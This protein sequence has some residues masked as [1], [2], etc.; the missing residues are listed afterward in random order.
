MSLRKRFDREKFLAVIN[1]DSFYLVLFLCLVLLATTA[2]WVTRNNLRFF[3]ENDMYPGEGEILEDY[4]IEELPDA[5][6]EQAV[7]TGT[8]E[9]AQEDAKPL[10]GAGENTGKTAEQESA[11]KT[12]GSTGQQDPITTSQPQ[13]SAAAQERMIMPL[14]GKVIVDFGKDSLVYSKT[15]EQWTTHYGIDIAAKV[16]T[17]VKAV[18]SGTVTKIETDPLLGI[19]ITI[20]H[21]GGL[22]TRYANLQNNNMVKEGQYVEKGKVISG[23][24]TSAEFEIGDEPHLHFE[25]LKNG[26]HQNPKLYLPNM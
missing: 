23:V 1:R 8:G 26:E 5:E 4:Q 12:T 2:I 3:S 22:Q 14:V 11:N 9:T 25:V 17:P 7:R 6:E 10:D 21:G 19:M 15:L 16:G 20:D 13:N 18:L 24:G